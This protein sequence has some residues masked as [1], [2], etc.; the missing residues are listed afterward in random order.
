MTKY[1]YLIVLEDIHAEGLGNR[2]RWAAES[3]KRIAE[4]PTPGFAPR[5]LKITEHAYWKGIERGNEVSL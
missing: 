4:A 3:F 1:V 2:K 5:V